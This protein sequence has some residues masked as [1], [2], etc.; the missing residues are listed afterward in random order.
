MHRW[1]QRDWNPWLLRYEATQVRAQHFAGLICFRER[2]RWM[3]EIE[4][5]SVVLRWTE[6]MILA[7]DG[8]LKQLLRI[9]TWNLTFVL[10]FTQEKAK[11]KN[12]APVV[13]LKKDDLSLNY[14]VNIARHRHLHRRRKGRGFDSRWVTWKFSGSCDNCLNCPASAR[15]YPRSITRQ[16]NEKIVQSFHSGW[17]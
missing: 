11:K 1:L 3:K 14:F 13:V 5:W 15:M 7:L 9:C 6:E 10:R 17:P 4:L 2:I 12:L 8:Q 16:P